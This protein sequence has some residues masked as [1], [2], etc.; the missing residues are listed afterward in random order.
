[1][2]VAAFE[3][4]T[5]HMRSM[6]CTYEWH[7]KEEEIQ[8]E[9]VLN[10]TYMQDQH[11]EEFEYLYNSNEEQEKNKEEESKDEKLDYFFH[12]AADTDKSYHVLDKAEKTVHWNLPLTEQTKFSKY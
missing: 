10:Y 12:H 2:F 11:D 3:E 8:V 9:N 1:M 7:D 6:H 4:E 5:S